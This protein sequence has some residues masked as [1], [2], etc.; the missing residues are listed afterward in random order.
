MIEKNFFIIYNR[1]IQ[2]N[3]EVFLKKS[4][5]KL[6]FAS[7]SK[8]AL[9]PLDNFPSWLLQN[10]IDKIYIKIDSDTKIKEVKFYKRK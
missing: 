3:F 6:N 5:A 1:N 4:P 2:K 10:K 7:K 9:F 8:N